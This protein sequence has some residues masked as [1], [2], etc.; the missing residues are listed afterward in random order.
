MKIYDLTEPHYF[1]DEDEE[2]KEILFY[3][4]NLSDDL[5]I[6]INRFFFCGI[7]Y[8]DDVI[9]SIKNLCNLTTDEVYGAVEIIKEKRKKQMP[10]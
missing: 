9:T 6:E 8:Y 1:I 10:F 7:H 4:L 3:L 5:V 2:K